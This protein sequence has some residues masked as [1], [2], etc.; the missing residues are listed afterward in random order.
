MGRLC[1][2]KMAPGGAEAGEA[3]GEAA[4]E[5]RDQLRG[6]VSL[7]QQQLAQGG[8]SAAEARE[9]NHLRAASSEGSAVQGRRGRA[10][11]LRR[12][13][14]GGGSGLSTMMMRSR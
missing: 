2:I 11:G 7:W 14:R 9:D 10:Q 8:G 5:V 13:A 1:D 3:T 4:G 12:T 6:A